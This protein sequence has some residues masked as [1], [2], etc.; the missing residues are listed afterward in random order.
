[1]LKSI[2]PMVTPDAT[3]ETLPDND[4]RTVQIFVIAGAPVGSGSV[5]ENGQV[6]YLPA[7]ATLSPDADHIGAKLFALATDRLLSLKVGNVC[8]PL[9]IPTDGT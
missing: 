7:A 3:L 9:H 8:Q 6:I 2:Q 1:M 5:S 4:P